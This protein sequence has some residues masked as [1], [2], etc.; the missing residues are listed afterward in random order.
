MTRV[1]P[2]TVSSGTF[3]T[4]DKSGLD[5][6]DAQN[7]KTRCNRQVPLSRQGLTRPRLPGLSDRH[8]HVRF[9]TTASGTSVELHFQ[10]TTG[11]EATPSIKSHCGRILI[12]LT[13]RSLPRSTHRECSHVTLPDLLG[14]HSS[15]G[16]P[17]AN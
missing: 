2:R 7:P 1:I 15:I 14:R 4:S 5:R 11:G 6:Y 17:R 9:P 12:R 16:H 8:G 10:V 3:R 13:C